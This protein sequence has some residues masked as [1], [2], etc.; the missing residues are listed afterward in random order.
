MFP[1]ISPTAL[2]AV[3]LSLSANTAASPLPNGISDAF[4]SIL[5]YIH[6]VRH[7]AYAPIAATCP[8]VP[9]VRPATGLNDDEANYRRR[10]K[11]L[12]DIA[13]ASW[14]EKTNE[15][16]GTENLPTI[17]LTTS[18]GGYRSL[19]TGAGVIQGLDARDSTGRLSGLLQAM[20]YQAGLSG[21][22]WLLSSLI[23]N[24]YP[25]ISSLQ[26]SLWEQA[27]QDSIV[28]PNNLLAASAYGDVARDLRAKQGAGFHTTLTDIYG[29]LLSYQLLYGDG[30]G[31]AT[32][33]SS[34]VSSSSFKSHSIPYPIITALGINTHTG[35]CTPP[36]DATTFETTPFEFG[37]WDSS[38]S[39]FTP[40]AFLGT[41]L[42]NG[43]PTTA[44]CTANYDNLG[45]VLGTTS[46][47]FNMALCLTVVAPVN[48]TASQSNTFAAL[49]SLVHE[50]TAAD[51]FA[52]YPNP[53]YNYF[54]PTGNTNLEALIAEQQFLTLADGGEANQNN[55]IIPILQPA[56]GI[57]VAIINDNSADTMDNFPN[58]AAL[59]ESYV[60]SL[61]L[62]LDRMPYIPSLDTIVADGLNKRPTFFGCE[63]EGK[64]T[65]VYLP[66]VNV[67]F[68]SGES[69]AKVVYSTD[70]TREMIENGRNVVE[71]SDDELW[72]TCLGC[73]IMGRA[74][75][76]LPIECTECYNEYCYF[77]TE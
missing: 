68:G 72:P 64:M 1:S 3:V 51:N 20:T 59:V 33:M 7:Q 38:L 4:N 21:G 24:N 53:F 52:L 70:E 25:T 10:R 18:G 34:V 63:E 60:Q 48:N 69:T 9:L 76:D 31:E 32:T 12:A 8:N 58:G 46:S 40:T 73:A 45:Y 35:A 66:N 74:G 41:S 14:L 2:I 30:G 67:T 44:A 19:L 39:A 55:P 26:A 47:L 54:S 27:F 75:N 43:V 49:L 62:G 5:D 16:F 42:S 23:G 71:R 65:V 6:N 61:V 29:R 77:G 22:G 37:S 17:A 15:G 56:R 57:D 28:L 11:E 36:K 13:L 50:N